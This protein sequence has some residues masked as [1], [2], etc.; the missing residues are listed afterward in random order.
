MKKNSRI[1]GL[2]NSRSEEL[3]NGAAA[4]RPADRDSSASCDEQRIRGQ[5][6]AH[7]GLNAAA[8]LLTP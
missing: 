7:I 6:F 5:Y 8:P 2:K 3:Q 1:Q 4:F